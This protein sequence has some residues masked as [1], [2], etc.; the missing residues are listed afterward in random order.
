MCYFCTGMRTRDRRPL[1]DRFF[2]NVVKAD[3][4][5]EWSGTRHPFG[6]GRI[7]MDG[8]TTFAHRASWVIHRGPVPEGLFVR[9]KCD[10]P[11][12]CNPDHLELGTAKQ[13]MEDKC[14]RGRAA[15]GV[16]VGMGKLL[17]EDVLAIRRVYLEGVGR[18]E[19][20]RRYGVNRSVITRVI[21]RKSH[22]Y[23]A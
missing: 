1:L 8:K 21:N 6:Y 4:C 5:W 18:S 10:N 14:A 12:C 20:A 23:L 7:T 2:G 22:A 13:N 3:G 16:N 9:H 11:P 17:D 15:R 19:L